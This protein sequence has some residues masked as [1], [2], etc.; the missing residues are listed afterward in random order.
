MRIL[1]DTREPLADHAELQWLL[2]LLRWSIALVW[3]WTGIV[4]LGLFPRADSLALLARTGITGVFANV[5]LYAAAALDLVLGAATLLLRRRQWLWLAQFALI[6]GYTI[7][8]TIKL[9]EFWLHPYGP[10][11]KNLPLLACIVLLYRLE[12]R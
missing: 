9:P 10:I 11:L 3:I 1:T 8:I 4:S 2:P 7:V 12:D 6:L 5:A